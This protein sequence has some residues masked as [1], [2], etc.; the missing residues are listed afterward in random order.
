MPDDPVKFEDEVRRIARSKWPDDQYSGSAMIDKR[1]VDGVFYTEDVIHIVECTT[2]TRKE[3]AQ[4][5]IQK[6][7]DLWK[8]Y[9]TQTRIV[10]CWFIT[11]NEPTAQQRDVSKPFF[12]EKPGFKLQILSFEQFQSSLINVAEYIDLRSKYRFGSMS[13][14]AISDKKFLYIP[15]DIVD[16]TSRRST[17]L[18]T[19]Q[20]MLLKGHRI[21][22][23][24]DYGAGKSTTMRELFMKLSNPKIRTT[25]YQFP[26]LL[27]LRDHFGQTDPAEALT[28]HATKIGFNPINLIRAWRAGYALIMLDGFDELAIS[29]WQGQPE[30]LKRLRKDSMELLR[31]FVDDTPS[32]RGLIL[33]GRMNYFDNDFEMYSALGLPIS[34]ENVTCL[35]I[36]DFTDDQVRNYLKSNGLSDEIPSWF[37]TRPLL[38]SSLMKRGLSQDVLNKQNDPATGWDILLEEIC[39][40]EA[41]AAS[42]AD[43]HDIRLLIERLASKA[44]RQADGLGPILPD[45]I[46]TTFKE[47]FS[48]SPDDRAS[49][50]IQRLPGLGIADPDNENGG[51]YFVDTSLADAA[52]S[53]D[54]SRYMFTPYD[55][56]PNMH[57]KEWQETL[58]DIGLD[59]AR[60][61]LENGAINGGKMSQALK[62]SVKRHASPV[63]AF[64]IFKLMMLMGFDYT[65]PEWVEIRG[66]VIDELEFHSSDPVMSKITFVECIVRNIILS[67]NI[68]VSR[69]PRFRDTEFSSVEGRISEKDLPDGIFQNCTYIQ[70]LGTAKTN[71]GVMELDKLPLPCRVLL[72]VLRK[73][74]NQKGSGRQEAALYRGLDAKSKEFVEGILRILKQEN[75]VFETKSRPNNIVYIPVRSQTP[76]VQSILSAPSD[77]QDRVMLLAA[78]L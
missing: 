60:L 44:R 11:L 8:K 78:K 59:I 23:L 53:G 7:F 35:M 36:R 51:R 71:D 29:G 70:F 76:R 14:E 65:D 24:G 22:L 55:E 72:V 56:I 41:K 68:D 9:S 28:R 73:L 5:D 52:R 21:T 4:Y 43:G 63:L 33:S 75:L 25:N 32:N 19:I 69:I 57:S 20:E 47:V 6:L 2:S 31:N 58:G 3:K 62:Q 64:D 48:F 54:V 1:E 50:L 18:E 46:I 40:R 34:G 15:F 49:I 77:S 13:E 38:L 66:V 74:Y 45:E 12:K 67:S 17:D 26:I 16:K 27:N 37:P 30:K 42:N 39:A 61:K 10:K